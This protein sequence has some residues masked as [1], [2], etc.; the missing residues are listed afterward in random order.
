[1][2]LQSL[3][4]YFRIAIFKTTTSSHSAQYSKTFLISSSIDNICTVTL[5]MSNAVKHATATICFNQNMSDMLET[6][7]LTKPIN[8]YRE[9]VNTR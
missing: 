9:G 8:I 2:S 1:M 7:V 6:N 3:N 4:C 5:T